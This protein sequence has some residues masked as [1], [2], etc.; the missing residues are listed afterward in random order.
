MVTQEEFCAILGKALDRVLTVKPDK[1]ID[2]DE[3]FSDYGLDS[4]DQMNMLLEIED[5]IGIKIGEV[6]ITIYNTPAKLFH[7]VFDI[8]K[9]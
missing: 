5:G 3:T 1:S 6:D 9:A 2:V 4:L 7:Y 8:S